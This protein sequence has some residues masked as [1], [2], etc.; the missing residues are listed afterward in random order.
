MQKNEKILKAVMNGEYNDVLISYY[1]EDKMYDNKMRYE[2]ALTVFGQIYDFKR[3]CRIYSIPYSVLLAGDGADVAIPTDKDFICVAAD[4]GT[5]ISRIR[6]RDHLGE[7][8]IDLYAHGPY[9]MESEFTI[10]VIRGVQ[11][12]FLEKGYRR[13]SG[14]D[15]YIDCDTLPSFGLDEPAH[16]ATAAAYIINDMAFNGERTEKELAEVVQWALANHIMVDSYATDVYASLRGV[17]VTGDFTDADAE[18]ITEITPD[19]K[20]NSLYVVTVGE[21]D[22]DIEE[23]EVDGRLDALMA[24]LGTEIE[25]LTEKDFYEKL[26]AFSKMMTMAVG[27]YSMYQAIGFDQMQ[28]YKADLLFFQK[29]RSALMMVY[30][31]KVDFSKYEDG[32]RSLLN[33]FVTSEPVEIV[34]EPV[35]IHDKAAMDQ[36]LEEVEGQKAKAAYIHTRIVSELESRRYEDPML[37]KRFS[38]RIRETIAEYKKS[39]DE[40]VYLASMKKMAEDLRQGFTGH[41]Y[42]SAITNDSDAKAFYGVVADT[43]KQHGEDS[44]EFDDAIGKLALEIKQAVQALARVDWRNS[45]PIHKKMNQ[46]V[47]DFLWDFCDEFVIDLPIDKMDLLI[48]QAIKTAMSRY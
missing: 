29:L 24:K 30:A 43:L 11:Q 38:E 7:D 46:T 31:E 16:L 10:G 15:M 45:T 19:L 26:A 13:I 9:S 33:T 1:G 20:G 39:R 41:S 27:N 22:I 32:I 8:N 3:E 25:A 34:V 48:E 12:A 5:N 2:E 18:V 35:A 17:A 6:C 42:P 28:K 14:I 44:L 23:E 40:N 4:N 36:Q 37:F 47:E 21:T